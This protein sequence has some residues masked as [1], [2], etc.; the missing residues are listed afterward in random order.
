MVFVSEFSN[1]GILFYWKGYYFETN[2]TC[3]GELYSL[4]F[5]N[6]NLLESTIEQCDDIAECSMVVVQNCDERDPKY[7][8][9]LNG[10]KQFS[11][12]ACSWSKMTGAL[13][14]INAKDTH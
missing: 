3:T 8:Y 7:Y 5:S 1:K 4:E 13:Y 2:T 10:V 11:P 6:A 14:L 12:T 9:C